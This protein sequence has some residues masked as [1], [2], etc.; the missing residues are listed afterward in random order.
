MKQFFFDSKITHIEAKRT[1]HQ[2]FRFIYNGTLLGA[3]LEV[4]SNS[5]YVGTV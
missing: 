4:I 2:T 5:L 3:P 1:N